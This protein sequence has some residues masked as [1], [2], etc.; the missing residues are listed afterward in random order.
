MDKKDLMFR[1][2]G[3][4]KNDERGIHLEVEEKYQ[5]GLKGIEGFSYL[6]VLWWCH[7]TDDDFLR[8]IVECE[9]PYKKGP[10]K[11][12]IFATRSP[13]RPNPLGLTAVKVKEIIDN[14]IY[15]EY[16]DAEEK[17]P[18]IDIKPYHP[19]SDRIKEVTVPKW[20]NHWPMWYE[21][22][23]VFD[24]EAEFENAR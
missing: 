20:C 3:Y 18:V 17:S 11:M 21:D 10:Q 7:L 6:N 15:L 4:I 9:S 8:E 2:I 12:G 13:I 16:I 22:S 24:W 14:K 5:D 1:P 23:A 19:S